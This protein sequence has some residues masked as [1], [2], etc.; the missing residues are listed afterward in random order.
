V[1]EEIER[2]I[3]GVGLLRFEN[4]G[5]GEWQT[6]KGQPAKTS[7]R[8]YLLDGAELDSVSSIVATLDKPALLRWVEK[9]ATLGAVR[10]ERE[11]EL[12]DVHPDDWVRRVH[13]LGFG[14]SAKKEE[15]ADRGKVIHEAFEMFAA[16]RVPNPADFPDAAFKWMKGA[17]RAWIALDPVMVESEQIICH[18]ELRYAGRFDLLATIDGKLTLVDYKTGKGRVYDSAHFQTALYRFALVRLGYKIERTVLVGVADDGGFELVECEVTNQQAWKLLELYQLRKRVNAG[19]A[20][21]RKAQKQ[22][23]EAA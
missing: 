16:G 7:R 1:S 20:A 19:M 18:P 10:A 6:Q 11:G 14:A 5:P 12:E 17:M 4:F 8:R 23:L 15:G 13:S 2:D 22:L 3:P 21:Q 9:E